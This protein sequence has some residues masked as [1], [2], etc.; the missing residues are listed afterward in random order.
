MRK[1][2][3]F[4]NNRVIGA[5]KYYARDYPIKIQHDSFKIERNKE[6]TFE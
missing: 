2:H 1:E 3:S 4:L 5:L 6:I